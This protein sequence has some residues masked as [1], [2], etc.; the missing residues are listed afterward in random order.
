LCCDIN[1]KILTHFM[2]GCF[3]VWFLLFGVSGAPVCAVNICMG[4]K[5]V[6]ILHER[7]ETRYE[8]RIH[9]VRFKM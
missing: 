9:H 4:L 6:F 7:H 3:I 2:G 5:I 1:E 8:K